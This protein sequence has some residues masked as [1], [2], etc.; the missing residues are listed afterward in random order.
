M[1][2]SYND[3]QA[4]GPVR[5]AFVLG[6]VA[7]HAGG[8]E[9]EALG[10][11]GYNLDEGMYAAEVY[12]LGGPM[13]GGAGDVSAGIERVTNFDGRSHETPIFFWDKGERVGV[14]CESGSQGF[15]V[16]WGKGAI[17][18]FGVE[19]DPTKAANII[20]WWTKAARGR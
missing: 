16:Y 10:L 2:A 6:G 4:N 9:G 15:Y 1:A 19:V 14:F 8:V 13:G 7:P 20:D 5:G 11:C 17:A 12:A 18:G 3:L